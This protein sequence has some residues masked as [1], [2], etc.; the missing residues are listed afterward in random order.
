MVP[1]P[2]SERRPAPHALLLA[3]AALAALTP[4]AILAIDR[5]VARL[6]AAYEPSEVWA[7]GVKLLEQVIGLPL[8]PLV[9]SFT[10]VGAMLVA[11][12]V[13]RLRAY[14][15][16]LMFLAGTHML[17]RYVTGPLKDLTGRLRP[18]EWLARG[19]GDTFFRDGIAFPS[20]H[21]TLFAGL[22]I[23]I[24]ILWPRARPVLAAA[25]FVA[26]A[27]I[28]VGAHFVS[29]ALSGFALVALVAWVVGL[30]VRPL[31]APRP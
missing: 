3:A 11:M 25:V 7:E 14:A 21:V 4:L 26:A 19:G 1:V 17:A 15:P 5:P 2:R 31:T 22:A 13:P 29:D 30:G 18:S 16:A 24:A 6:L 12:A 8:H 20:G 10:L 23:P 27:R 9:V 28:A